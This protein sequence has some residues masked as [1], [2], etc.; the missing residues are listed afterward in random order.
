MYVRTSPYPTGQHY[1]NTVS[2]YWYACVSGPSTC[3]LHY[4]TMMWC[5]TGKWG[6]FGSSCTHRLMLWSGQTPCWSVNFS[7]AYILT[8]KVE[9]STLKIIKN[10][11]RT[12]LSFCTPNDLLEV[13]TEGTSLSKLSVG[14]AVELWW[15]DSSSGRRVNQ[16]PWKSIEGIGKALHIQ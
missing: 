10:E 3:N 16:K 11:R 13:N 2:V 7:S 15:S 14:S 8:S 12:N 9:C 4:I 6:K 1:N 5:N